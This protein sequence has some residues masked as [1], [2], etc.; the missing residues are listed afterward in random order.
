MMPAG[1]PDGVD[2]TPTGVALSRKGGAAE[3]DLLPAFGAR[4][5]NEVQGRAHQRVE[6]VALEL[7][8]P[9]RR[10]AVAH[11]GN[12]LLQVLRGVVRSA[13]GDSLLHKS[14]ADRVIGLHK[15]RRRD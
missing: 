9:P 12:Q 4:R 7:R 6:D 1:D 2:V 3:G 11:D 8:R 10:Q 14:P 5:I 15:Q 13:V